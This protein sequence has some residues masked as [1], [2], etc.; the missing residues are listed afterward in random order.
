MKN[1]IKESGDCVTYAPINTPEP[2]F[3]RSEF[4][5]GFVLAD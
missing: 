4:F 3:H 1:I 5:T 2:D